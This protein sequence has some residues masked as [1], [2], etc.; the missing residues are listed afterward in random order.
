MSRLPCQQEHDHCPK[1]QPCRYRR[2]VDK[3]YREADWVAEH[4]CETLQSRKEGFV[5]VV[6]GEST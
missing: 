1:P 3:G 6:M 4:K 5:E 2:D